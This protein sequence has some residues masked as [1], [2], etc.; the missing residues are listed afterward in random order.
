MASFDSGRVPT[1]SER[2][3]RVFREA[4]ERHDSDQASLDDLRYPLR[5][6]CT[7]ARR[8]RMPPEEVVIRVKHALEGLP[9]FGDRLAGK[10]ST[11][12][13]II[14]LAIEAYYLDGEH[15]GAARG[16]AFN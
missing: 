9:A 2:V 13:A 11:R 16:D 8:E 10:Q 15:D 6:F 4:A 3:L 14:S 7:Q 5:Q 12:A 1:D